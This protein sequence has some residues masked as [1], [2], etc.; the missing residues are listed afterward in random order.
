[1]LFNKIFFI[2]SKKYSLIFKIY[3][4][5]LFKNIKI[6][7]PSILSNFIISIISSTVYIF[8]FELFSVIILF[9]RRT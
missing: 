6:F 3:Y 5:A 7:E 9:Y 2:K 8:M 1:M 4:T